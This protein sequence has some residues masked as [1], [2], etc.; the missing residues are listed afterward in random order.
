VGRDG[1]ALA[2]KLES[3]NAR[4][5]ELSLNV[6]GYELGIEL[7]PCEAL[8]GH[9][10]DVESIPPYPASDAALRIWEAVGCEMVILSL[11][12]MHSER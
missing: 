3:R 9:P 12:A 6:F 2:R 5:I 4:C 7:R 11:H 8:P 1:E 10:Y